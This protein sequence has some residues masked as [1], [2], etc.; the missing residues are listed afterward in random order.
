MITA[1]M[2]SNISDFLKPLKGQIKR[3]KFAVF[4]LESKDGESKT[5]PGFT[6]VFLG[7]FFDGESFESFR[8]E[9]CIDDLMLHMLQPRYLGW[10]IYAH[11]GGRFD[12]LHILP[13]LAHEGIKLGYKFCAIPAGKSGGIQILD[14][15]KEQGDSKKKRKGTWRFLDS[16]KLIPLGLDKA[17][18]TLGVPGKDKLPLDT[19]EESFLWEKYNER[20]CKALWD[21]LTRFRTLVEDRLGGEIGITAPSTAMKTFRKRY[22]KEELPRSRSVHDFIFPAYCGGR[23]EVF[24]RLGKGL[25]YYDINSSYPAVMCEPMPV[26][27]AIEWNGNFPKVFSDSG[28]YVGFVECDVDIPADDLP[29]LP[30]KRDGKLLFPAG[31][32]RGVWDWCEL[33][34]V[35]EHIVKI[36]RSVWFE[37]KPI[38]KEMVLDLYPYRDKS[39]PGYEDGL[40]FVVKL[41]LNSL[42]GK[43]G[44][45]PERRKVVLWDENLPKGAEPVDGT[46]DSFV[47]YINE[48]V[49][50]CYIMPQ[51]AAHVTA[52]ARVRLYKYMLLAGKDLAYCDTDSIITSALI[53]N[54]TKLGELKDEYPGITFEGE[55]LAPKLYMLKA[56][57]CLEKDCVKCEPS[58]FEKV[59]AKGIRNRSGETFNT[60]KLGGTVSS[61]ELEKLGK[62]AHANFRKPEMFE[63]KKSLKLTSYKREWHGNETKPIVLK[64][65]EYES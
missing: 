64:D 38:L 7:G 41:L 2:Q 49:E 31:K 40:S 45:K 9:E 27:P 18:K 15:W 46:P 25:H 14:V 22:L 50:A 35:K 47:W 34:L 44:Q 52:L 30:L 23:V 60:L 36:Y 63:L 3:K 21:V 8:G 28:R 12:F 62:L 1:D 11:N 33:E 48:D 65:W 16:I 5:I 55:F 53:P 32:F 58:H 24:K 43:F 61:F 42:Y 20:D 29:V 10:H 4:D 56:S 17:S 26:G 37:S 6:R 57:K 59:V 51:I 39:L 13:W 54:S 19:H